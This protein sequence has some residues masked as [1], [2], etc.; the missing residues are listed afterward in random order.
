MICYIGIDLSLRSTG[1]CFKCDL[2]NTVDFKLIQIPDTIKD[3]ELLTKLSDEIFNYILSKTFT[4]GI[5]SYVN[6]EGLSLRS[7]SGSADIICG[8]FWNVRRRIWKSITKN[9]NII[10]VKSWREPLFNKEE[11]KS[12]KEAVQYYNANKKSIKGLK[13]EERKATIAFNQELE[14]LASIKEKTF[15]KLPEDVRQQILNITTGDGKYDL[16]DAYFIASY[17]G[18]ELKKC[19]TSKNS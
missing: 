11:R 13:G 3:E 6:I 17:K 19:L 7:V 8:N 5:L 10:P 9:V 1:L 15:Q 16:C 14:L 12:L 4:V 18:K 2:L